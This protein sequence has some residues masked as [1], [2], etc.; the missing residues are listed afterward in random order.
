MNISNN[1]EPRKEQKEELINK[2]LQTI[3]NILEHDFFAIG[4]DENESK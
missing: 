2:L 4:D 1:G 3:K